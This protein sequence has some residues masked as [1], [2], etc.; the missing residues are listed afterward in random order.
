MES[1]I[2]ITGSRLDWR[3]GGLAGILLAGCGIAG[4][5]MS[6]EENKACSSHDAIYF[7][8]RLDWL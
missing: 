5:V 6:L 3:V 8:I 1:R 7:K 2:R 4:A